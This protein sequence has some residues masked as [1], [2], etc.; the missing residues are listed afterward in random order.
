MAKYRCKKCGKLQLDH[1]P[2]SCEVPELE[3]IEINKGNHHPTVKPLKLM[4]YL[5]TITKTPTGGIVYDPFAGSGTTGIACKN[6]GREFIGSETELEYCD[7]AKKRIQGRLK[8]SKMK[9]FFF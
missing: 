3:R 6:T 5:C 7:I 9:G 1:N 4:E 8:Q 2:C